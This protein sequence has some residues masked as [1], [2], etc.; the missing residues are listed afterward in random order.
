MAHVESLPKNLPSLWRILR[1]FWPQVRKHRLLIVGSWTALLAEVG[2]RL[3]EPW[4]LKV[5]FDTL[6]ARERRVYRVSL[7]DIFEPTTLV[8]MAAGAIV[9]VTALRALAAYWNTIGF[10]KLGNRVLTQVRTQLYRHV[11]Y[12]SLSF[13]TAARTGDLVVR[14]ISDVGMLQ[15]VVVTAL[16]PMLAKLFIL[17]GMMALMFYINWQLSVIALAVF[18]LFWLRTITI[19]RRIR[20]VARKQ[21]Q[22]EGLMAATA[23]ESIGAIKTV[24]ALSLESSFEKVFA[25]QNEKNLKQDIKGKRLAASLERSVDVLTALAGALVLWYGA[26]LVMLKELTPGDLLVF[27]AYLKNSFRP[28]QD[29]AKYTGRLGKATAAGERILD[30][31]ERVPDV[32]DLPHAIKAPVLRGEVRFESVTFAYERGQRVLQG[33]D[34]RVMPGQSVALVGP[35]GGGKTTLVGLILRLYDPSEGRVLLD[36]QDI[37]EFT[38]ES[39][40]AQISVVLQDNLL[41]AASVRDNIACGAPAATME[42]VEAAA[43]LA[44]A[45]DFIQALPQCYD[46]ILGERGVTVSQ[47]QRQRIAIARAA[48]RN[49]P[50]LILDEPTAALDTQNEEAVLEALARLNHDRTTFLITHNLQQAA[51]ADLILYLEAGQILECGSH[52]ELL[53]AN[54]RYAAMRRFQSE[55]GHRE[56]VH[57]QM[58]P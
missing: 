12:L 50:I 10:A 35:S 25:S 41:F 47:G 33:L 37:R 14:V 36:G 38:L 13:H 42:E 7:F 57:E 3:L 20:E 26:R 43:R 40:R 49:A 45:H 48:I 34:L 46:T 22:R 6:F 39:L 8:T 21:R 52:E 24:Q 28:I 19:G 44:N 29:F 56:R 17:A 32:R 15:D 53:R 2:L 31:L 16:L 4:P 55:A 27:L 23:A 54:N 30:L 51:H 18:P 11:Q 1:H 9:A 5:L 58:T